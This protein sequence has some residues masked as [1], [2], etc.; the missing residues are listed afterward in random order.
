M[1]PIVALHDKLV[2][3]RDEGEAV[4]VVEGLADILAKGETSTTRR[5]APTFAVIGVRPEKVAHGTFVRNLEVSSRTKRM[6]LRARQNRT[7][8]LNAV[9][10]ADFI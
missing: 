6:Q 10:A 5:N 7:N 3:T 2:S 1:G 9:K 8:F 4:G